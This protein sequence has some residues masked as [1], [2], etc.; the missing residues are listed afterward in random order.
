MPHQLLVYADD[1]N[2]MGK[3][4]NAKKRTKKLYYRLVRRMV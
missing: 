3:N 2:I 1:V 4:I